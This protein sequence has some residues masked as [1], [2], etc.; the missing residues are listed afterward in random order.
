[1][2]VSEWLKRGMET[3]DPVDKLSNLWR[4]FNNLYSPENG[5]SERNKIKNYLSNK[6]TEEYASKIIN[7]CNENIAYLLFQP[8]IDM[9]GN[10]QNTE[11]DI[12]AFK[13]AKSELEKLKSLFLIIYQVRCNLEHGQKSP[14]QE[15]DVVLCMHSSSIVTKVLEK[16]T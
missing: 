7:E 9:R 5:G 15:R 12:Y 13:S 3:K 10:G 16:C 4:G 2:K 11:R 14:S 1:M 8:V 6:I